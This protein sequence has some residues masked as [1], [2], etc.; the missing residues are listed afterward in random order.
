MMVLIYAAF[1]ALASAA[2]LQPVPNFGPNP[3]KITM[4]IYVP[5]KLAESPAIVV[6]VGRLSA[7]FTPEQL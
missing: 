5:N 3:S 7:T 6:L 4:N 1:A 2:S